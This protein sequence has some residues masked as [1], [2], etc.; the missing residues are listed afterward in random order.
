[1]RKLAKD[2][3]EMVNVQLF[4]EDYEKGGDGR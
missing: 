4:V 1:M 2:N 3:V